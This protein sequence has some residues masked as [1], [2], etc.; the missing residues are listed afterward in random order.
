[1]EREPTTLPET[2]IEQDACV[3]HVFHA[4]CERDVQG[5]IARHQR[6]DDAFFTPLIEG[7]GLWPR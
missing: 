2:E 5:A 4:A 6:M 7:V 1:M 3:A